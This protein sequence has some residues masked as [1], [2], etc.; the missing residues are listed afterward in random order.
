MKS[1]LDLWGESVR[2]LG[3]FHELA[4]YI[5]SV[6]HRSSAVQIC[7]NESSKHWP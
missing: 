5:P 1:A 2:L 7:D 4:A 3:H 6:S